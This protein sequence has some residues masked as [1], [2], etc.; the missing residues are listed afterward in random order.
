MSFRAKLSFLSQAKVNKFCRIFRFN[1][2]EAH[3]LINDSTIGESVEY[4]MPVGKYVRLNLPNP[5]F[6]K[7]ENEIISRYYSPISIDTDKTFVDFLIRIYDYDLNQ[8]TMNHYLGQ[9]SSIID[10]Y[11]PGQ[12][13][14][15]DYPMG[16]MT[17]HGKGKLEI[18][19]K[20]RKVKKLGLIC[21]GTGISPMFQI[22]SKVK[23]SLLD[24]TAVSL[25]YSNSHLNEICFAEDL[26]KLEVNGR[27]SYFP[28]LE[29]YDQEDGK[30]NFGKGSIN[31][32]MIH[33]YMPDPRDDESM[34]LVC[35]YYRF[36]TEE[37]AP[38]LDKMGYKNYYLFK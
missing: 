29:S 18:E 27:I 34:I 13:L 20:I 5:K 23:S 35:G 25:I 21:K 12:S 19:G 11:E 3:E 8:L 22:I 7:P 24:R 28:V 37:I 32:K 14:T 1:V 36:M 17:Y 6:T 10:N 33:D 9:F 16:N 4:F 15:M 2:E 31:E 26:A 38:L 30:F